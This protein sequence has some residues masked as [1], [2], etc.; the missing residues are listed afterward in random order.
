MYRKLVRDCIAQTKAQLI[1]ITLWRA[2]CPRNRV[3]GIGRVD[4]STPSIRS[5]LSDPVGGVLQ[6]II[7]AL[8]GSDRV[9]LDGVLSALQT[10]QRPSDRGGAWA[11]I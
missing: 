5:T 11:G 4:D 1:C 3:V 9:A 7:D 10:P 2:R 8:C 6:R